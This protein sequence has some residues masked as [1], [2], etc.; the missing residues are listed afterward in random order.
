MNR[1][2]NMQAETGVGRIL[3]LIDQER[4]RLGY[5]GREL[6]MRTGLGVGTINRILNKQGA[7][8]LDTVEALAQALGYS[9]TAFMAVALGASRRQKETE[10]LADIYE[11]LHPEDQEALL[12]LAR[13][14]KKRQASSA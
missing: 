5:S 13:Y 2:G 6:S 3:D 14:Y 1:E 8:R 10:E 12:T 11:S 4:Q 9:L 7:P